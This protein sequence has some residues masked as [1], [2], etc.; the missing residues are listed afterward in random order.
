MKFIKTKLENVYVIEPEPFY[1]NRGWF[2]R[3][4]CESELKKIGFN[5]K[6][7][8]INH[9]F[10]KEKGSIRGMHFQ[11]PPMMEIKVIKCLAGSIYDVIIDLRKKSPTFLN[12]H[13][14][15]ISAENM[16]MIYVPEGYAHGFQTLENNCEILYLHSEFYSPEYESG[17]RFDDPKIN[18]NWPLELTQISER[19][20]NHKLIDE[21]F[22]W[23]LI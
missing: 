13:S 6:I 22:K 14:E 20:K 18:I 19:D 16:K 9:S 1:D 2:Q 5:K 12:W 7:V 11:Y 15:I 23:I 21:T 10:T 3:L 4:Y 8:Q 17:I